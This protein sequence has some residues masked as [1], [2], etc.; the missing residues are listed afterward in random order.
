MEC[1]TVFRR[2]QSQTSVAQTRH[3]D[4][5]AAAEAAVLQLVSETERAMMSADDLAAEEAL[6]PKAPSYAERSA[7]DD[8][9]DLL[10]VR[11]E[12]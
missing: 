9:A 3:R 11:R 4:V 5:A 10:Q 2:I 6:K 8:V 1:W 7:G 12:H